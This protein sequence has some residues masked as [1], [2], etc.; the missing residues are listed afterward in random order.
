MEE[1][2]LRVNPTCGSAS[3]YRVM[4]NYPGILFGN[5]MS[6]V[7]QAIL[8]NASPL[9]C[10]YFYPYVVSVSYLVH[11]LFISSLVPG[12]NTSALGLNN[13]CGHPMSKAGLATV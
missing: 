13:S 9:V 7:P 6:I 1:K 2:E 5:Y 12:M 8:M 3:W 10:P 11:S 4:F